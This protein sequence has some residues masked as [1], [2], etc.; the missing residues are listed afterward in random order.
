MVGAEKRLKLVAKDI[1]DHWDRR[2]EILDGKA[3]IVTMSRRIC[4]DLYNQITVLRP[5]WHSEKDEEGSVK[6]V[7]T[8]NASDPLNYQEHLRSK[9][10]QKQIEKRF[11]DPNDPL[12]FVIVRDMW[13]T[14]FDVPCAHTLYLDKPMRGHGLMQAIARVNRVFR[15][16]PAGLVVDYL[17][18]A[19]Q[20]RQ[21]IGTYG[22]KKGTPPGVPVDEALKVLV[23]K[24]D[25][26][27]G[28][29]HGFNYSD[30]FITD[31]AKRLSALSGGVNHILSLEEGRKRYLDAMAPLNR[32]AALAIHLEGARHLRDD[33][34][35][36]QSVEKN[37]RKHTV[38]GGGLGGPR[39]GMD[40]AIR[41]IVSDA[42]APDDV[43]DIF[44]EAGLQKPDISILSDEFF[45]LSRKHLIKIS[46]WNS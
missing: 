18:I 20:L 8:G 25:I 29:F 30:Y 44:R 21:A 3:M 12:R 5:E 6:I 16:K 27:K 4:V 32:A 11:K 28:M 24:H 38:G 34:G 19:E 17:G 37:I 13:L 40:E 42:I 15:D 10:R 46:K 31:P 45:R 1:L 2:L 7:M 22:G 36:F 26:V 41:Q 9:D 23:E 14:G 33:I 35:Y 43:I 39:G